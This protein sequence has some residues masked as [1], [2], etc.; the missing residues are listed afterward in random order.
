MNINRKDLKLAARLRSA[1]YYVLP[2]LVVSLISF[3]AFATVSAGVA[4]SLFWN[5]KTSEATCLIEND[6]LTGVRGVPGG[7]CREKIFESQVNDYRLNP[8]GFRT[9]QPCQPAAAGI[10][11]I[12]L[13]GSSFNYGMHVDQS[14]MYVTRLAPMLSQQLKRP[15]DI[16]NE[17]MIAGFPASWAL[18]ANSVIQPRP[19]LILWPVTPMDIRNPFILPPNA[20]EEGAKD[21]AVPPLAGIPQ[22]AWR[23]FVARITETRPV[24]MLQHY[25]YGSQSQYLSHTLAEGHEVDYLRVP[26]PAAVARDMALF[27]RN[28][29][30]VAAR[31][32]AANI[33][34]VVTLLPTR[35]QAIMLSN[36][37]W[38]KG[39]DPNQLGRLIR[40]VVEAE[41]EKY[42]DMSAGLESMPD[43]SHG[44]LA[45]DGH[46]TAE[47]HRMFAT[48]LG[49]ALA[50]SRTLTTV[51]SSRP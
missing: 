7:F 33:P 17:S 19:S 44:Y 4:R 11:R 24:F 39:Y 16:Y 50:R 48:L 23:K 13:I 20:F 18:R 49:N 47:G 1:F 5:T 43:P 32:K 37:N 21:R 12:V 40:G 6:R 30:V 25:L 10:F 51:G 3:V 38:D 45:V 36:R 15:V 28:F 2:I 26:E 46:P 29:H 9:A 41:G 42:I 8:C 31:A 34:L 14:D 35:E 27:A 22:W